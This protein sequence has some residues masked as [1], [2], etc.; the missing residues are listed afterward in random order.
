MS[1]L[2]SSL[3]LIRQHLL[4]DFIFTD[5]FITNLNF[6]QTPSELS[7]FQPII[8]SDYSISESESTSP[9]SSCLNPK[10]VTEKEPM[11]SEPKRKSS[12]SSNSNSSTGEGS[13]HYRGVR[14]RPWS[15]FAAEIRDPARKG[16]RV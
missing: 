2:C 10:P 11:S 3:E 1:Q 5:N 15:K 16:S 6:D 9:V 7:Y 13:R 12:S 14:R 8:K 4:G